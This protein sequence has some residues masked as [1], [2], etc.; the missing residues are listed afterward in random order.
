M[1]SKN[2]TPKTRISPKTGNKQELRNGRWHNIDVYTSSPGRTAMRKSTRDITQDFALPSSS[3]LP[4]DL[5]DRIDYLIATHPDNAVLNRYQKPQSRES[6]L[7]SL[8]DLNAMFPMASLN[9]ENSRI[10]SGVINPLSVRRDDENLVVFMENKKDISQFKYRVNS[11]IEIAR[12]SDDVSSLNNKNYKRNFYSMLD[13]ME[14]DNNQHAYHVLVECVNSLE[15]KNITK[16]VNKGP[17]YRSIILEYPE[18]TILR[19]YSFGLRW[20][21]LDSFPLA[22]MRNHLESLQPVMRQKV[23]TLPSDFDSAHYFHNVASTLAQARDNAGEPLKSRIEDMIQNLM[24]QVDMIKNL[25]GDD[26][27]LDEK[28]DEVIDKIVDNTRQEYLYEIL[29]A[30]HARADDIAEYYGVEPEMDKWER[31]DFS[32][33]TNGKYEYAQDHISDLF[34][35]ING[36]INEDETSLSQREFWQ[37]RI[38]AKLPENS[39]DI[40]SNYRFMNDALKYFGSPKTTTE[41]MR[42]LSLRDRF[43]KSSHSTP[44]FVNY[45][46]D[47]AFRKYDLE[48]SEWSKKS[49][50]SRLLSPKPKNKKTS[51]VSYDSELSNYVYDYTERARNNVHNADSDAEKEIMK[52]KYHSFMNK[53][54]EVSELPHTG[55]KSEIQ[56]AALVA[57]FYDSAFVSDNNLVFDVPSYDVSREEQR[58]IQQEV[59]QELNKEYLSDDYSDERLSDVDELF[60]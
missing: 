32:T 15:K 55:L 47:N 27:R 8:H 37:K 58:S 1:V 39:S 7:Q 29:V 10:F 18:E 5:D 42:D 60:R 33:F 20:H 48:Q 22:T 13:A 53:L 6:M 52:D 36:V 49:R 41:T 23:V 24:N 3:V 21:V 2:P 17:S 19:L 56:K 14:K 40:S 16:L 25:H 26:E 54:V 45:D 51:Y 9:N 12:S 59:L 38:V 43:L 57:H 30:D 35:S 50:I 44:F 11:A 34:S 28:L 4:T 46:H 31:G